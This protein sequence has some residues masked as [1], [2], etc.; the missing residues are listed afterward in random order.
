MIDRDTK[1]NAHALL[2]ILRFPKSNEDYL[3]QDGSINKDGL[4]QLR[5]L[6]YMPF[7]YNDRKIN[8][9][10]IYH[11]SGRAKTN[12]KKGYEEYTEMFEFLKTLKEDFIE[13]ILTKK[14][15]NCSGHGVNYDDPTPRGK[16]K[17]CKGNGFVEKSI[18]EIQKIQSVFIKE[19]QISRV[20]W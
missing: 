9:Y 8:S 15:K 20:G 11:L 16:C 18:K 3:N 4:S 1:F 12:L 13:I 2:S 10:E 5:R 17:V 14:C 6:N 7:N 19:Q